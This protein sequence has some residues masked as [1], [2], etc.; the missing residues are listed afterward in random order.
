[1]DGQV[2]DSTAVPAAPVSRYI[3]HAGTKEIHWF[4]KKEDVVKSTAELIPLYFRLGNS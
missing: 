3:I 4:R 1:M 2:V